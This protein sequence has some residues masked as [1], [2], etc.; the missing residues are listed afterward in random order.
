MRHQIFSCLMAIL[1]I[2]A[3]Y[4][5]SCS[6]LPY[7]PDYKNIQ[8]FVIG[9]EICN[10]DANK[11]YWL[12]DFTY[13]SKNPQ[14]GDTLVLNGMTYTN[15]LKTKE[16]SQQLKILGFRVSIDY[17]VISKDKVTTTDC[18]VSMAETFY[19]KELTILN[20]GEIR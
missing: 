9:K 7:E 6:K 5:Y 4:S 18:S 20:Q 17:R 11:D 2:V 8:G 10:T 12:I 15:V 19:L 13:G 14:V 3:T 1:I 16:L